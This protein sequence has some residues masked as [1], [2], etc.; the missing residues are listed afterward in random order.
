MLINASRLIGFPILS[1]H[2]GGRIAEI[3]ELIVDPNDLHLIACRITGTVTAESNADILTMDS[4]REFCRLG[5]I[6]D[7]S[8]EF[9]QL[10]EVIQVNEIEKLHFS[11]LGMQVESRQKTKLGKVVDYILDTETWQVHQLIVHRPFLKSLI[12]PELTIPRQKIVEITDYKIYI[13]SEQQSE[14]KTQQVA[15]P[16]FTPNFVNPFRS[17]GFATDTNKIDTKND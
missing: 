10:E 1:L 8:D 16:D 17:S 15:K 11:L 7:S 12:D 14:K 3:S 13:D 9:A 4:V 5:M 2:V 6:V